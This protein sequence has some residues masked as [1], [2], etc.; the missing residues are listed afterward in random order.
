MN[1]EAKDPDVFG[2]DL[3]STALRRPDGG[4]VCLVASAQRATF[5]SPRAM[6]SDILTTWLSN[7]LCRQNSTSPSAARAVE[8]R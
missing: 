3:G 1:D 7:S 6:C 4:Y 5:G 2:I 8:R